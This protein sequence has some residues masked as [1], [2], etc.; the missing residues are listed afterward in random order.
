MNLLVQCPHCKDEETEAHREQ[1]ACLRSN[2]SP[3]RHKARQLAFSSCG[4]DSA[5]LAF[6]QPSQPLPSQ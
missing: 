3:N 2:K 5:S 1:A 4:Q 6:G